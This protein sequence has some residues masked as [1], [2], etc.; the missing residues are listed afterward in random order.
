M[1][2]TNP[3]TK[4]SISLKAHNWKKL[5]NVKN[6]SVIIN[7]ALDLYFQKQKHMQE[8]EDKWIRN[9]VEEAEL[10]KK[11]GEYIVLNPNGEEITHEL[12]NKVLWGKK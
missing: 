12:L 10:Q 7:Q 8:A 3:V 11:N 9:I 4:T 1:S 5:K 2:A 6:R